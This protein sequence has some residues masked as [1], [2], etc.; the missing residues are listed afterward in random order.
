MSFLFETLV[1]LKS[2]NKIQFLDYFSRAGDFYIYLFFVSIFGERE[3]HAFSYT[4]E[5]FV[6]CY[7]ALG[8]NFALF[9]NIGQCKI[10]KIKEIEC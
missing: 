4:S 10:L 3:L 2:L 1:T 5:L 7:L 8:E 6:N 9:I